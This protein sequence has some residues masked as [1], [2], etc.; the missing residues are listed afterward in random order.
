M[1][2]EPTVTIDGLITF[3]SIAGYGLIHAVKTGNKLTY[4][5]TKVEEHSA[6]V[7]KLASVLEIQARHEERFVEINRR[8]NN[9]DQRWDELRHGK[10]LVVGK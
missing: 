2:F 7:D 4:L 5:T 1:A 3:L 9:S 6:K 10:G 8:L